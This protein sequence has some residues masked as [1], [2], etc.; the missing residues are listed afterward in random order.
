MQESFVL[1]LTSAHNIPQR[2]K[3]QLTWDNDLGLSV[4]NDVALLCVRNACVKR[5][6][7]IDT[8]KRYLL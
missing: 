7:M 3:I 1:G 2:A 5:S 4:E 8:I 6:V